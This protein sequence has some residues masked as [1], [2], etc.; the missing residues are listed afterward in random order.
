MPAFERQQ[1][2]RPSLMLCLHSVV[3]GTV[4]ADIDTAVGVAACDEIAVAVVVAV[5]VQR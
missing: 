3:A 5:A 4:V 1:A 2:M